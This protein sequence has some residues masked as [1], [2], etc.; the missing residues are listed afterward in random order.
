MQAMIAPFDSVLSHGLVRV[1]QLGL[2]NADQRPRRTF[3]RLLV[4]E[5]PGN[6]GER[7]TMFVP[8]WKRFAYLPR[9][10]P[11]SLER[12]YSGRKSSAI[13]LLFTFFIFFTLFLYY[14]PPCCLSVKSFIDHILHYL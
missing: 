4:G 7:R 11:L 3:H 6:I 1:V 8:C 10:P 5:I 13:S 12:S 9:T 2:G 14:K